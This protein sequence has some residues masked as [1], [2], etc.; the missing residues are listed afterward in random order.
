MS[1]TRAGSRERAAARSCAEAAAR[2]ARSGPAA[3]ASAA[4]PARTDPACS[5]PVSWAREV[6]VRA[7]RVRV[8]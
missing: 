2:A 4:S 5:C 7:V 6:C 3:G 1:S 8:A